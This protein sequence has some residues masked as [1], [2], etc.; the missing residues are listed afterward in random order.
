MKTVLNRNNVPVEDRIMFLGPD[1]S[2]QRYDQFKYKKFFDLWEKQQD[3]HWRPH[4]IDLSKDRID[5]ERLT[6]V[7]R[8]V[9]ESNIRWQT[10]TD[11]MLSRSIHKMSEYVTNPELE[12]CMGVWAAMEQIHSFSYTH[13]FKNV[14]KNATAFFD[15]IL[16]DEAI[17]RRAEEISAAYDAMLGD[18]EDLKQKI[19][20][21][22]VCTNITE[23]VSFYSSFLCSF[24]FGYKGMMEGSAKI[25]SEIA[26]DENVHIAI[27]HQILKNWRT[28]KEEGFQ[29]IVEAGEE[30]IYELFRLAVKNEKDWSTYL[31]SRGSLM[32]LNEEILHQFIEYI[33]NTRL[34]ALGMKRIFEHKKDPCPWAKR[35]F[36]STAVQVAPQE[37]E[38]E[39]YLVGNAN[40]TLSDE[41]FDD[42]SL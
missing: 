39:S 2:L 16:E 23:G 38:L 24:Y 8:F 19:F 10:M 30:K 20:N 29:E 5:Y 7:E 1:L 11:S 17:V 15:S 28:H 34:A 3:F 32:G 33:A 14:T 18:P 41:D 9:F 21:A 25:I 35:Y 6:D 37:S 22:V 36:N 12:L 13:I 4:R 27:T 42:I 26:R 40:T 31:F